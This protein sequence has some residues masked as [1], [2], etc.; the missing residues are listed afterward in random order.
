MNKLSDKTL[1]FIHEQYEGLVRMHAIEVSKIKLANM[2]YEK[3]I[4]HAGLAAIRDGIEASAEILRSQGV[5]FT[6]FD[7]HAGSEQFEKQHI[8]MLL[9]ACI[10]QEVM[11]CH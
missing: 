5:D 10:S 3:H 1:N 2:P 4:G 11:T 8:S 9:N 7:I 6:P